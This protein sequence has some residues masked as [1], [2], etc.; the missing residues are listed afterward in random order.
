MKT[1]SYF[2]ICRELVRCDLAIFRQLIIDKIIDLSVWASISIFVN[3]YIM[4]YFGVIE[5]FGLF[6]FG[7]ILAAVGIFELYTTVMDLVLD[8]EGDRI[9]DYRL[10][11]PIPSWMALLSKVIYYA[12]TYFILALC[13]IPVG[14]ICLWNQFDLMQVNYLKLILALIFQS[15]LCACCSIFIASWIENMGKLGTV[16]SRFIFPMWFM[17]GFAFSWKALYSVWPAL[18]WIDL[19]NPMIYVTES[20]RVAILGQENF[21]NFWLCLVAIT[22]FSVLCFVVGMSKI[23]KRLDYV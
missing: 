21:L 3:G 1:I 4:P 20:T 14:K 5:G 17:G 9:I 7:G 23:K 15:L 2:A 12:L 16:W 11:L 10:T 8:F 13:M 18:A 6:Q 22:F 19:V